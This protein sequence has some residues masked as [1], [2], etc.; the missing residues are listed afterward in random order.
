MTINISEEFVMET[1]RKRLAAVSLD[2]MDANDA[3]VST[4]EELEDAQAKLEET[5]LKLQDVEAARAN[6]ERARLAANQERV[7][8]RPPRH[9]EVFVVLKFRSPVGGYRLFT[10]QQKSE[11]RTLDQFITDNPE[12][13]ATIMDSLRF[14]R[15]PRGQ[16]VYQHMKDDKKAP[17]KFSRRNFSIEAGH[18]EDEMIKYITSVF[19]THT[20]EKLG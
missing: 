7:L 15:S 12:L 2:L 16:F 18:T 11:K 13:D 1:L 20:Q 6:S 17:I 19:N 10:L 8:K 3:L 4:Q 5:Q 14:E 9:Q